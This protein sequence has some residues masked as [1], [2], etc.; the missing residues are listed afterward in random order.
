M[1]Q[2]YHTCPELPITLDMRV[3]EI[4]VYFSG[5]WQNKG[6]RHSLVPVTLTFYT[7]FESLCYNLVE[8]TL[9][10]AIFANKKAIW[11]GLFTR[12]MVLSA[13]KI[14]LKWSLC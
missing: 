3:G 9:F 8:G 1:C 13:F 7:Q 5:S 4:P 14:F 2:P 12:V 6:R 11:V 10:E